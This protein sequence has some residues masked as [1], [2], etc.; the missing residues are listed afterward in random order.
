MME[1]PT[2]LIGRIQYQVVGVS[3]FTWR[4]VFQLCFLYG[5]NAIGKEL[6]MLSLRIVISSDVNVA[7]SLC[8]FFNLLL[9]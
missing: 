8:I 7:C 9:R 3:S 2:L 4:V 5:E 6:E 1:K